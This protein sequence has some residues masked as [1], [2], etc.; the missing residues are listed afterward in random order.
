M[1][2]DGSYV[3][4]TPPASGSSDAPESA[5]TQAALMATVLRLRSLAEA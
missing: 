2:S 4:R 5:G 3:Q 1:Q